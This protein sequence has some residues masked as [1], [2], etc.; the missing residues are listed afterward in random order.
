[1]E[2][3]EFDAIYRSVFAANGLQRFCTDRNIECFFRFTQI[4]LETNRYINL[5]AI[6]D[7]PG[8]IAKHFADCLLEE[9]YFPQNATVLD[10]GCGGGFPTFPLAIVRNDL[11]I[12]ALDGTQKKIDF[13]RSAASVLSL[14]NIETVCTRAEGDFLRCN[15]EKFDVVTSRATANL[16]VLLEIA[17]PYVKI[18]GTMVALKGAKGDEELQSSGEAVHILGGGNVKDDFMELR[19][20]EG[21]TEARHLIV[22]EK[23][24]ATPKQFPRQYSVITKKPL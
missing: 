12:T 9:P 7:V 13:V 22:I 6:R 16:Q 23:N 11:K 19:T 14:D 8:V 4:F 10:V 20:F 24:S 18:G 5:T 15:R 17:F 3:A 1:M 21:L 2:L